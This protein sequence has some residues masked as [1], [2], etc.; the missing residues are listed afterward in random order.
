MSHATDVVPNWK[1]LEDA[2]LA[3][4]KDVCK[5]NIAFTRKGNELEELGPSNIHLAP[6][7][8]YLRAG[9]GR[10]GP[11]K[12][13]TE[14]LKALGDAGLIVKN[15]SGWQINNDYVSKVKSQ[16]EN[17]LEARS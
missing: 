5:R 6:E 14:T 11:A 3:V 7:E 1:K 8:I 17:T 10:F 9:A 12:F 4:L 2:I 13:F 16:L 15:D